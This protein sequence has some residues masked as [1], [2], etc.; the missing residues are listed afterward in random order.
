[1]NSTTHTRAIALAAMACVVAAAGCG[2]ERTPGVT[3]NTA[4]QALAYVRC[5]RSHGLPSFPD[6]GPDGRLPNVP[7]SIDPA[8]PSFRAA[9]RSCARL[10]P[11]GSGS[12]S[13]SGDSTTRLLGVAQCMR[14]HGLPGFPDPTTSPPPAPAPGSVAGNVIGGPGGYLQLP[15][16]SPALARAVAACGLAL[17]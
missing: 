12:G 17:R 10:E 3:S 15:P 11:G 14:R 4:G 7:S 16:T 2:S 1:V 6:P 8:A 9:Q 13:A 5:L